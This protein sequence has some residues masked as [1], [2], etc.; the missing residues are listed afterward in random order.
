M[1]RLLLLYLSTGIALVVGVAFAMGLA[2]IAVAV[3]VLVSTGAAY[4]L[5]RLR[6][7]TRPLRTRA[8]RPHRARA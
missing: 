6:R 1:I 2:W 5:L 7:R 3:P 8:A 4:G